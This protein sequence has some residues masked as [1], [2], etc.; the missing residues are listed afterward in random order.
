MAPFN[1][2]NNCELGNKLG[3][4]SNFTYYYS[5]YLRVHIIKLAFIMQIMFSEIE[6][7]N[8]ITLSYKPI[9]QQI[10]SDDT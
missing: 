9:F 6:I 1:S 4:F 3:I 5:N 2:Q 10:I 8:P 7:K